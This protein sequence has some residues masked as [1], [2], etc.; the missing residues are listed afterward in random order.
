MLEEIGAPAGQ[1]NSVIVFFRLCLRSVLLGNLF[2]P[3]QF[4]SV[5]S[6]TFIVVCKSWM[7]HSLSS[8]WQCINSNHTERTPTARDNGVALSAFMV[9]FVLLF[10]K[11]SL[12]TLP[13]NSL[14]MVPAHVLH[15]CVMAALL[16][17]D[18]CP[19]ASA[20]RT[21]GRTTVETRI[22]PPSDRGVSPPTHATDTRSVEYRS[23][24][25]VG[26]IHKKLVWEWIQWYLWGPA[27]FKP[28]FG[29]ENSNCQSLTLV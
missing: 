10:P 28:Q 6:L 5:Y 11:T 20:R 25:R 22:T 17:T 23:A 8:R 26:Q 21:S 16:P 4:A 19:S 12:H 9:L 18:S 24:L 15:V 2:L 13:A 3:L 1:F 29:C 14:Q 27:N 7:I